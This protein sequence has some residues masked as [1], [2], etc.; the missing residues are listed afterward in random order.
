MELQQLIRRMLSVHPDIVVESSH[1]RWHTYW[2]ADDCPLEEF[3]L[4]QKQ[5][6]AKF[7][8]DPKVVD[9]PRVMRLPGFL[10][11]KGEPFLTHV[12]YPE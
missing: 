11:Q 12:T 10:H 3:T 5:I 7:G 4:R 8:S 6:A 2:K 1:G 9:L